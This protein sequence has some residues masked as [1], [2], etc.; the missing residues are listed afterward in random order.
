MRGLDG[1]LLACVLGNLVLRA[2]SSSALTVTGLYL[3][4]LDRTGNHVPA[5]FIGLLAVAFYASEFMTAPIFGQL[6]DIYGKRPFL[7]LGG[8]FGAGAVLPLTLL[9]ALPFFVLAKITAGLSS[10][11]SVPAVLS[12][13]AATTASVP[14][15]RGRIMAAFEV[16]TLIGFAVGLTLGGVL[17]DKLH[18]GAFFVVA[19]LFL[20]ASLIFSRIQG[21]GL[22]VGSHPGIQAYVRLLRNKATLAFV[23]AWLAVNAVLGTWFSHLGFQMSRGQSP[24]Q[25]LV[26]DYTG[27]MV[28]IVTG[29]LAVAIMVGTA[30][31]TP[32]FGRVRPMIIMTIA[33]IGLGVTDF[34]IYMLNHQDKESALVPVFVACIVLALLVAAGFTP[35]ALAH[36]AE[37]TEQFPQERGTLMGLYSVLLGL[38]QLI[39]GWFGGVFAQQWAV[40]GL[41]YLTFIFALLAGAS[42]IMADR[43]T[44]G[45]RQATDP[46]HP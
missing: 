14:A 3:G 28:G 39:G 30:A 25:L 43:V 38:G 44:E 26:G 15:L 46:S 42:I 4:H 10:G 11:S 29:G 12:Y 22:N 17:W 5:T 35:A 32:A 40:D 13:L 20:S 7:L 31:W 2:G 34:F 9:P 21:E 41:I 23:P 36:L 19:G 18:Q 16:A 6:T 24:G 27:T 33:A 1:S 37:I 8:F 45:R